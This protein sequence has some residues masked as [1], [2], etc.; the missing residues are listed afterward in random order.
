MTN[1]LRLADHRLTI[2]GSPAPSRVK[3]LTIPHFR[4]SQ[5]FCRG[6][7]G[8]E[9]AGMRYSVLGDTAVLPRGAA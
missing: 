8:L 2:A 7:S 9:M 3:R 1:E 4:Q 5:G 6:S